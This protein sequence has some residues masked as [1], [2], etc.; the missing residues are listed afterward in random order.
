M[1]GKK[2]EWLSLLQGYS[3]LLVVVGHVTLT[4]IYNDPRTPIASFIEVCIYTFHMPLFVFISGWLFFFTCLKKNKK[5]SDVLLSKLKRFGF[6]FLFFTLFTTILK[7]IFPSLMNREVNV[8]E[9]LNTFVFF[10]SNP[11]GEMWFL[12]VLFELML[13]YP[14]YLVMTKNLR[15]SIVLF[16]ISIIIFYV[17]PFVRYFQLGKAA[18]MLPFFVGG[19]LSSKYHLHEKLKEVKSLI[20]FFILFLISNVFRLLPSYCSIFVAFIGILFSLSLCL[21]LSKVFPSLFVSFRDYTYQIFLMGIFFQMLIRWI[22]LYIGNEFL[23]APLYFI[24]ILIGIYVP[25]IITVYIKNNMSKIVKL[26]FGL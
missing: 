20:F 8:Q 26:C 15:Y 17:T 13:F 4:N 12:V 10:S 25:T 1:K 11:L 24:S 19:I 5:F 9:L 21:N 16:L 22:Y 23:F 7:I 14:L 3:M 18:Y 6:P 2:I